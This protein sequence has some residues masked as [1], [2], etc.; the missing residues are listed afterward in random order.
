MKLNR[1][2]ALL[3]TLVLMLALVACDSNETSSEAESKE[4]SSQASLEA[5]SKE[6]SSEETVSREYNDGTSTSTP[7][8]YK[9]TDEDGDVVWLF[10]SI[11]V[12][13]E[14]FYP[15]PDYVEEA[16][17]GADK[18]AVE[19]DI[20]AFQQDLAAQIEALKPLVYADGTTIADHIP[21][22]LY[23]EAKQ[24]LTDLKL[25]NSALDYYCPAMWSS[26]ID[27]ALYAE[28]GADSEL[29]VDMYMINWAYELEME[30]VDIESA[31]FQ[32]EM[33][34]GFSDDLQAMLLKG[35]L[36]SVADPDTAKE[37][38][39]AMMNAWKTGDAE[40]I[41]QASD[42]DTTGMTEEELAVYDEYL[43]AMVV[44]RNRS[45]TQFAENA[46]DSGKEVFICVGALHVLG[47]GGMADLL[48]QQGYTVEQI[49]E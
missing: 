19:V 28:M 47:E 11:H 35:S 41:L 32:Y 25:Y 48:E 46:L 17:V 30:V 36:Q 20:I 3:L 27:S 5:E 15:L 39:L 24:A 16:F 9:V 31:K 43:N 6:V 26:T 8:L 37:S 29:G 44:E 12:G 45:M 13:E 22:D 21:E 49:T 42:G 38:L 4:A 34:A 33:L 10:G 2:L 23:E 40:G 7:V 1:L 18:L 14:D